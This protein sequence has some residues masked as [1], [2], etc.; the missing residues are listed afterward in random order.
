MQF[1]QISGQ[2]F[3][4]NPTR[5]SI[6]LFLGSRH[7][8]HRG[9]QPEIRVSSLQRLYSLQVSR[10]F[11]APV[12]IEEVQLVWRLIMIGLP[13]DAEKWCDSDSAPVR[14]TAGLAEFLCSVKE[15]I[16]ES[17]F[18]TVPSATFFNDRLRAVSRMRVANTNWF[19]KVALTIEKVR[20][21]PSES[22]SGGF[23]NVRSTDCPGL[24][25]N[26]VGFSKW[27]AIVFCATS[28]G[29]NNLD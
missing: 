3:L 15:P 26:P 13:Y 28:T 9:N 25:S 22:V 5:L 18:T 6:P 1:A 24:K 7:F 10:V 12:G 16:A 4:I 20:V 8:R 23:I 2:H 11:G 19:S 27:K 17:I 29:L 21:F 14:N